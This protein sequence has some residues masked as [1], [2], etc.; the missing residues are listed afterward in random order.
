MTN[1]V[2]VAV[3]IGSGVPKSLRVLG[4][5]ACW[6]VLVNGEQRG[7]AFSS[8]VE[9]EECRTAWLAQLGANLGTRLEH[10]QRA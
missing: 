4:Q 9:A 2:D 8:R 5:K 1:Q 10:A 7:T 3:M 6:V